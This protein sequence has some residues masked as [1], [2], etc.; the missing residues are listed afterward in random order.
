MKLEMY[1]NNVL[2]Y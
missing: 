2:Q 1:Q